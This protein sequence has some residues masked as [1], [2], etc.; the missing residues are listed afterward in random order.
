MEELYLEPTVGVVEKAL[1]SLPSGKVPGGDGIPPE[2]LKCARGTLKT[3]LHE[4][5][6]QC[7]REVRFHK[8]R[9][10]QSSPLSTKIKATSDVNNYRG[11]STASS[12]NSSPGASWSG[13]R[14]LLKECTLSHSTVSDQRGRPL[15]VFF[16]R[17]LQEKCRKQRKFLYFAFTALTKAFDRVIRDGLFKILA[18]IGCPPTLLSMIQSFHKDMNGTVLYNGCIF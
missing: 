11:I 5:L 6:C 4:L 8:T 9:D 13:F 17:Q 12:A 18:K 2:V 10:M 16:L 7:W 15:T 1:D 14:F 3:E